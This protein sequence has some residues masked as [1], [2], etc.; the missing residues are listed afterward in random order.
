MSVVAPDFAAAKKQHQAGQL[1]QAE[2]LY[3]AV[4]AED[5]NHAHAWYLL[6]VARWQQGDG[7]EAEQCLRQ[8]LQ[9]RPDW[10]AAHN[11]LGSVLARQKRH[12]EAAL[13]F[14]EA[15]RLQPDLAEAHHNLGLVLREQ[16]CTDEALDCF[17]KARHLNP[18]LPGIPL[19]PCPSLVPRTALV[20]P[21]SARQAAREQRPGPA[22]D[23][24]E[25]GLAL[26]A[27]GEAARAIPC[28]QQALQL[29]GDAAETHHHLGLALLMHGRADEAAAAFR[30]T[31]QCRPDH[32]AAHNSLGLA[33]Y[34]LDHK[35]QALTH[36]RQAV[37]LEALYPQAHNNLGLALLERNELAEAE[38]SL[39]EAIRLQEDFAEAYNNLGVVLWRQSDPDKWQQALR[40]YRQALRL[41]PDY[42]EARHNLE[43]ALLDRQ[44]LTGPEAR[45]REVIRLDPGCAGA[46]NNLGVALLEQEDLDGAESSLGQAIRLQADFPEAHNNL[47]VVLWRQGRL[48]EAQAAALA[49]LRLRPEFAE[50]HNNLGNV[51]HAQGRMEEALAHF[52]RSIEL[53]PDYADPHLNRAL[54]WLLLGRW[55]E[56][57]VEYEWR[58]QLRAVRRRDFRQPLWDGTPLEGRTI[59]LHAEQ[60]L[61]D[62]LNFI[63]YAPLVQA[64]DGRVMVAAPKSLLPLLGHCRGIDRLAAFG[65]PLPDFDV[66]APLLTLPR[67]FG[68]RPENVPADVPYLHVDAERVQRWR[69]WLVAYQGFKVGIA[70]QGDRKHRSDRQRSAAL[71]Q[72]APL[73]QVPGVQLFSL[74][75]GAGSE[76]LSGCPFAVTD[77]G[78]WLDNAGGAFMDTAAVM[79]NLDLVVCVDTALGHLAGG[80]GVPVWL[81]LPFAPDWRWLRERS[82]TPWYPSMRLFRQPRRGDWPSMFADMA[83][84]LYRQLGTSSAAE[85]SPNQSEGASVAPSPSFQEDADVSC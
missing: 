69:L 71:A 55:D 27:R 29:Q 80:L 44:R 67:L 61:G 15:I 72:L 40:H 60:G 59:L 9:R 47:S 2:R 7:V 8:A 26:L 6:G 16:G 52:E 51:C 23:Y 20:G 35:A 14:R 58:W 84:E 32:A 73:A 37:Q 66:Q 64:R 77:L 46:H 1:A 5:S 13:H 39:R 4:L 36:W 41:K 63:R 31:L 83:A 48:L 45:M 12:V 3:R 75:K 42:P 28:F 17:Q 82:D 49:A 78:R 43:Q 33:L 76:Q 24:D 18:S 70:W 62:T 38:A 10:A 57:W 34:R 21:V 85:R 19:P 54:A 65:E 11:Y 30:Q 79:Q 74:Q 81:A 22:A 68:T 25:Q 53:K 56:G 50:A